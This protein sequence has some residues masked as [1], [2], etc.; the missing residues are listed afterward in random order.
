MPADLGLKPPAFIPFPT[1]PNAALRNSR[2]F[3]LAGTVEGPAQGVPSL[4]VG[5]EG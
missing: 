3:L 2:G 1:S 5:L 4:L